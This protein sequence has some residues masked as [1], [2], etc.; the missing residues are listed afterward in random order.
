[1]TADRSS[2]GHRPA[3]EAP[4]RTEHEPVDRD[5]VS[6]LRD[7]EADAGDEREIDDAFDIDER[8]ALEL[9][10]ALDRTAPDE[11]SLD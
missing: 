5:G 4:H 11:P 9:G 3:D 8:E 7:I 2:R 6:S 10:V 1:M